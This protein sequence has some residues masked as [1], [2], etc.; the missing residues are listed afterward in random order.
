MS[1][2][3]LIGATGGVGSKLGPML[4]DAGHKVIALHRNPQ[5][6]HNIAAQGMTPCLGDLMNMGEEDFVA[7]TKNSDV[8]V[9]SA[10]AAGSGLERT[11]AIGW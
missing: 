7:A 5:Q 9:F 2:I 4:V 11:S 8:I 10:G 1:N 3:F 6:T